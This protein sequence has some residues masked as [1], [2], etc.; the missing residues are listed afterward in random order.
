MSS[1]VRALTPIS[2]CLKNVE[3]CYK[4][5]KENRQVAG[6]VT[7]V[8]SHISSCFLFL[9]KEISTEEGR[10]QQEY[11]AVKSLAQIRARQ[12][13]VSTGQVPDGL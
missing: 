7:E 8:T 11:P 13:T 12:R 6:K 5:K 2:Y 1:K 10:I 3:S 4:G 9:L